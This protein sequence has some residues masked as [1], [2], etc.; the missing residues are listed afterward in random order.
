MNLN[1]WNINFDDGNV[2]SMDRT[3]G[4]LRIGIRNN[5]VLFSKKNENT[6]SFKIISTIKFKGINNLHQL[7][8]SNDKKWLTYL[9][10]YSILIC[11]ENL[12]V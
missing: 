1:K 6:N 12:L 11:N 3:I 4:N 5:H 8:L 2:V 7:T 10:K 9:V